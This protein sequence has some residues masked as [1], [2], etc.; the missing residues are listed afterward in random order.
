MASRSIRN[1]ILWSCGVSGLV[2]LAYYSGW[3][4]I[5]QALASLTPVWVLSWAGI[6]VLTRLLLVEALTRPIS[7]IGGSISRAD[8]FWVGWL[9]SFLNQIVPF[10]GMA[11]LAHF[12][13]NRTALSWGQMAALASPQA[14]FL[15]I[16]VGLV[17]SGL[18]LLAMVDESQAAL[19]LFLAFLILAAVSF[20]LAS[21]LNKLAKA[22]PDKWAKTLAPTI[23]ALDVMHAH[24]SLVA[25]LV[26]I[27]VLAILL[28]GFRLW[29]L[30]AAIGGEV[31]FATIMLLSCLGEFALL[32][33]L[34]PG[35]I[36]IREGALVGAAFFLGMDIKLVAAVAIAD[37]V[38][39]AGMVSL[40]APVAFLSLSV[41]AR[42]Q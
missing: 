11:Y 33:Q 24:R 18:V 8:A 9:R 10:G 17:G 7:V 22:L 3:N 40:F 27:H 38:L 30:F 13:R 12:L 20:L 6:V 4:A 5:R 14:L 29:L 23:H 28:R 26:S 39:T 25:W 36:G 31:N 2:G 16:A 19:T 37:R 32:I 15:G 1:A 41:R 34:T 42:S 21:Q 35:G